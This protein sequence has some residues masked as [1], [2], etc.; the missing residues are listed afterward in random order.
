MVSGGRSIPTIR[1]RP[2]CRLRAAQRVAAAEAGEPAE[3][4]GAETP[5]RPARTEVG[6]R[7][8]REQAAASD[9]P[10]YASE[11][12]KRHQERFKGVIFDWKDFQ[13]DGA[14]FPAPNP[15]AQ[16]AQQIVAPAARRPRR[17]RSPK[18]LVDLDLR[19]ANLAWHPDGQTLA[20]TADP[21]W[22][23]RAQ[24]QLARSVDGHDRRQGHAPDERRLRLRRRRLLA[25][26]QVSCPTRARSAPT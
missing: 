25:R 16:P 12:E 18:V 3:E 4:V 20:F 22:R 9:K 15:T 21:D 26:R 8:A 24:V 2:R 1:R 11:F 6:S 7:D 13:R 14:E 10:T 19:P 5:A 17:R 23:E